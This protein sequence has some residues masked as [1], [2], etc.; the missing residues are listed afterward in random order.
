MPARALRVRATAVR[1]ACVFGWGSRPARRRG[2]DP[3]RGRDSQIG[4]EHDI[5]RSNGP[6]AARRWRP[7]RERSWAGACVLP[8]RRAAA[9][10]TSSA[11]AS[12]SPAKPRRLKQLRRDGRQQ[13]GVSVAARAVDR[14]RLAKRAKREHQTVTLIARFVPD[15]NDGVEAGQLHLQPGGASRSSAASHAPSAATSTA[16]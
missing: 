8:E 6:R 10:H 3:L 14:D 13:R 5:A 7:P 9:D 15:I 16:P 1:S 4:R 12:A 2:R 11:T